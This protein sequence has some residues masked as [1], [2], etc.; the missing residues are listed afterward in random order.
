MRYEKQD[1]SDERWGMGTGWLIQP[2]LLV[3]AGHVVY[4]WTGN[5]GDPMGKAV[6][7]NAYIGYHGRAN[8]KDKHVQARSAQ[9]IV[10]TAEWLTSN[11]NRHRDV[12]F[13]KLNKPFIGNLNLFSFTETPESA[14]E[15]M[16][17]VVGYP[18]DKKGSLPDGT[19]D[20]GAEMYELFE[21]IS[22]KLNEPSNK[23]HMI[24]YKLSTYGGKREAIHD[25]NGV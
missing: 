8:L 9:T 6:I 14:T 15:A 16:L 11:F 24:Q 20:Q 7:I 18:A 17:G 25:G 5:G 10:T 19:E 23:L 2:D 21:P 1:A 22:F 12:A 3:T 4:D 13:I